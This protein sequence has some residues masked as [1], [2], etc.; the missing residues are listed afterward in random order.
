[1]IYLVSIPQLFSGKERAV[2]EH[3]AGRTLLRRALRDRGVDLAGISLEDLL[4]KGP[5]G[6]LYLKG[7]PFYFSLSHSKGMAACA[8]AACE[9]GVD[10]ERKRP[11][12]EAL[13]NRI[14]SEREIELVR[15][16]G[17]WDGSL[18]R[19]WTMK[20]SCMKFTGLGFSQGI[21]ETEFLDL[22]G[23]P[24]LKKR[25]CYFSCVD[26]GTAFLTC[27]SAQP[28]SLQI[29]KIELDDLGL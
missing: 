9:I 20:E 17:N 18:T 28:V 16:S 26:L 22:S 8:A 11:F 13:A 24:R 6:K 4:Q 23:F 21:R 3:E 1:M 12:S 29:N 5:H 14:C 10:L 15:E 19:L 2:M 25:S 27:C 7:N